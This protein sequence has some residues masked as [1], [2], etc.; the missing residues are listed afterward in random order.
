MDSHTLKQKKLCSALFVLAILSILVLQSMNTGGPSVDYYYMLEDGAYLLD[1]GIPRTNIFTYIPGQ[2]LVLQQW[3]YCALASL[4]VQTFGG[5]LGAIFL[6]GLSTVLFV[7]GLIWFLTE[8]KMPVVIALG[9]SVLLELLDPYHGVRPELL[10]LGLLFFELGAIEHVLRTKRKA[11]LFVLPLVTVLEMNFHGSMWIMHFLVLLPYL[12]PMK[13]RTIGAVRIRS[14]PWKAGLFA[15]GSMTISIFLNPYG[16]DG[17]LYLFRSMRFLKTYGFYIRE[18]QPVHFPETLT[19]EVFLFHPFFRWIYAMAGFLILT[20][21]RIAKKKTVLFSDLCLCFGL[22]VLSITKVRQT[23]WID[24]VD[25]ILLL[26]IYYLVRP[27]IHKIRWKLWSRI[28]LLCAVAAITCCPSV[29]QRA[30]AIF[31]P[32]DST[33]TPVKAVAY[34]D[35]QEKKTVLCDHDPGSFLQYKD[36]LVSIDSRPECYSQTI[37]GKPVCEDLLRLFYMEHFSV[38]PSKYYQKTMQKYWADYVL[39][40][41]RNSIFL[42]YLKQDP[43]YRMVLTGKDYLLFEHI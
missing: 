41:N 13:G 5:P 22:L 10:T 34:M 2:K 42:E 26:W 14:L 20:T 35:K 40:L 6:T 19:P 28:F 29:L 27:K 23:V 3:A 31:S 9:L 11:M 36:Y 18:L 24:P 38:V 7:L 17:I 39:T 32:P 1:H 43:N 21:V 12:F 30:K 16:V 25:A 4:L 15:V 8:R 37:G 33:I